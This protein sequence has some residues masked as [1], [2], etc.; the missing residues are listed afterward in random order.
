[1]DA[2]RAVG[3]EVAQIVKSLVF[4]AAHSQR[5]VL[6]VASGVNRVDEEHIGVLLG[7]PITRASPEFV[8]QRTGFAIG[9]VAPVGHLTAPITFIDRDLLDYPTLWA[10][11]GTPWAVFSLSPADLQRLTG[12]TVVAVD[13]DF[14][15]RG[16]K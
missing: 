14:K 8:R 3:C 1:V 2:A 15:A 16:D 11:A 9:G 5:P 4:R 10:A 6:V 13:G 7:E 12:G